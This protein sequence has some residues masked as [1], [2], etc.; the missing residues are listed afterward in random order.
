MRELIR[1]SLRAGYKLPGAPEMQ[2]WCQNTLGFEPDMRQMQR[3]LHDL[4]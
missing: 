4:R 1:R 2:Q 3:F